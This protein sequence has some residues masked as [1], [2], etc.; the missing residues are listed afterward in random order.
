MTTQAR[1]K[2]HSSRLGRA[3]EVRFAADALDRGLEVYDPSGNYSAVDA[4]VTRDGAKYCR[5]QVK[6]TGR[7]DGKGG[8][9]RIARSRLSK[10]VLVHVDVVAVWCEDRWHFFHA[11]DLDL[12]Q[13]A[14]IVGDCDSPTDWGVVDQYL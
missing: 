2:E 12:A 14:P 1:I 7:R 13:W 11:K 10:Q 5:V 3:A 8:K 9:F 6:S 4:L